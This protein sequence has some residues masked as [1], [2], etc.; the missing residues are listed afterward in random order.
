MQNQMFDEE[1]PAEARNKLQKMLQ[2]AQATFLTK[3]G[4][5]IHCIDFTPEDTTPDSAVHDLKTA[6]TQGLSEFKINYELMKQS[7]FK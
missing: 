1:P 2:C 6:L 4:N 5:W 7:N 3:C